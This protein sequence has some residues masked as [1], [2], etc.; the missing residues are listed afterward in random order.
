M[1]KK[2]TIETR[3]KATT[4]TIRKATSKTTTKTMRK[5]T[6]AMGGKVSADMEE[7]F[8][9]LE[10]GDDPTELE[11]EYGDALDDAEFELGAALKRATRGALQKPSR[12]PELYDI[13]DH[14]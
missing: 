14:L 4:E 2:R 13:R 10:N 12:D 6:E 5:M 1:T 3:I 8:S 9:R 11:A 7:M